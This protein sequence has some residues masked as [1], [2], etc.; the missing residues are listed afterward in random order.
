MLINWNCGRWDVHINISGLM[1]QILRHFPLLFFSTLRTVPS[2][3]LE[4]LFLYPMHRFSTSPFGAVTFRCIYSFSIKSPFISYWME[5]I[6]SWIVEHYSLERVAYL[7]SKRSS[8]FKMFWNL[9]EG[10]LSSPFLTI[11]VVYV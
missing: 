9:N 8:F 6:S 10:F 1:E 3:R 5:M 2:L 7:F 11:Y 4:G